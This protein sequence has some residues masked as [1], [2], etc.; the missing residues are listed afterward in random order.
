VRKSRPYIDRGKPGTMRYQDGV[1]LTVSEPPP[2]EIPKVRPLPRVEVKEP[3]IDVDAALERWA[4]WVMGCLSATGWPAKTLLARVI[5]YGALG[6][7]QGYHGSLV[8][9]GSVVE[10]DEACAW[11][12]AAIMRLPVE[13]RIV[14]THVYLSWEPAEASAKDLKI[15]RGTFDSRLSRARRSVKDYLDGRKAAVLALQEKQG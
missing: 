11:V 8:L 9:V 13:E 5:E 6:A 15:T 4:R 3:G 2:I 14:I 10:D 12:E 7:A 1:M